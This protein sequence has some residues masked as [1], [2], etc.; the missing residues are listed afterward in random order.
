M[1]DTSSCNPI[2]QHCSR[3]TVPPNFSL[4]RRDKR[5]P[6][7]PLRAKLR[8]MRTACAKSRR[9]GEGLLLHPLL[10]GNTGLPEQAPQKI[11]PEVTLV[12]VRDDDR[13]HTSFHLR[14][15]ATGKGAL[16]SQFTE[17][18]DKFLAR[19]WRQSR[20]GRWRRCG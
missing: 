5:R 10:A 20:H 3:L 2:V 18:L 1:L 19:N 8:R 9:P 7:K 11:R 17:P 4:P 12:F 6:W 16:K 14:V 13:D 15:F